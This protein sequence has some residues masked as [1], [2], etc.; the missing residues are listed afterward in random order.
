MSN[1]KLHGIIETGHSTPFSHILNER[2]DDGASAKQT[3]QLV[4]LNSSS[5]FVWELLLRFE[6]LLPFSVSSAPAPLCL[7]VQLQTTLALSSDCHHDRAG[8][9]RLVC[10][11]LPHLLMAD[12]VLIVIQ[13]NPAHPFFN[14]HLECFETSNCR[15]NDNFQLDIQKWIDG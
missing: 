8:I 10:V 12:M 6:Y 2:N 13:S 15:A 4:K 5:R 1:T 14:A 11:W 3:M 7:L 9:M